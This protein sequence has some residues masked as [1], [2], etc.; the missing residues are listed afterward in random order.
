[1]F[2]CV[3]MGCLGEISHVRFMYR[4]VMEGVS[5]ILFWCVTELE[6]K[7]GVSE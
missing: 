4:C 3:C 1:M 6:K 5:Y 2:V 7:R